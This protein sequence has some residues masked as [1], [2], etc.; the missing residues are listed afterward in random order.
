MTR[1]L[2]LSDCWVTRGRVGESQAVAAGQD[3]RSLHD[4]LQLANVP[5]PIVRLET[6]E[7][8]AGDPRSAQRVA[9]T[10]AT[11]CVRVEPATE[12]Q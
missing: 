6:L 5:G 11:R 2:R 7:V 4:V 1:V 9:S 12:T 8:V 10:D 3:Q